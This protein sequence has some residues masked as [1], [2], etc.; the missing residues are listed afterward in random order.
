LTDHGTEEDLA[1]FY[2]RQVIEGLQHCHAQGVCHRDLKPENLLLMDVRR[3]MPSYPIVSCTALINLLQVGQGRSVLKIAD[4]GFSSHFSEEEGQQS[5][6]GVAGTMALTPDVALIGQSPL[7]ALKSVVG[8]PFYAAPEVLQAD[9]CG[10]DGPKADIWSLGIILYAML[11]GN[12]PFDQE[13]ASCK[14]FKA[15]CKWVGDNTD[16]GWSLQS[17]GRTPEYPPWLFPAKFSVDVRSLIVGLL[18]PDPCKRF[19][20]SE[21][22]LHPWCRTGDDDI[23]TSVTG[24][25]MDLSEEGVGSEEDEFDGAGLPEEAFFSM[26]DDRVEGVEFDNKLGAMLSKHCVA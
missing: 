9:I 23:V 10:Y 16:H 26:E 14:R 7:R 5:K 13:F 1:K 24:D 15:F 8:S 17:D 18:H 12:L 11:A 22:K 21:A 20:V 25:S 4:F 19:S 3:L 2:F 6:L